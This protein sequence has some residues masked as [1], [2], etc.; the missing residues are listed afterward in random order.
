MQEIGRYRCA[1]CGAEFERREQL[2]A[3]QRQARHG[4]EQPADP[5]ER[6]AGDLRC[7][8]CGQVFGSRQGLEQ[9]LRHAH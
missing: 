9:H 6:S 5:L 3:H 7:V 1:E 8:Q 2:T 4:E